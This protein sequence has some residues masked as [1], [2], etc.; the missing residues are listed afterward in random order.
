MRNKLAL[1]HKKWRTLIQSFF[2]KKRI[3]VIDFYAVYFLGFP[4]FPVFLGGVIGYF[5][6]NLLLLIVKR[7]F[8][9]VFQTHPPIV[10]SI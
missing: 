5:V 6:F 4:F 8:T 10:D 9:R 3:K 2:L 7:Q 1:K